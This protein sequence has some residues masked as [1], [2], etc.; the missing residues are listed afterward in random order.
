MTEIDNGAQDMER[1]R[2]A[3]SRLRDTIESV[4]QGFEDKDLVARSPR[5]ERGDV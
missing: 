3:M 1:A 2:Q 4:L 5:S